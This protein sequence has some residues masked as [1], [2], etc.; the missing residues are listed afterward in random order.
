MKKRY[1]YEFYKKQKVFANL[2][3]WTMSPFN[4]SCGIS[5]TFSASQQK[6]KGRSAIL[7]KTISKRTFKVYIT[8]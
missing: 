7:Q 6:V 8:C 1:C 3:K 4:I 2:F 5:K